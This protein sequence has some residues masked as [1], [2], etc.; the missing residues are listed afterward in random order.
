MTVDARAGP[1]ARTS[2][3]GAPAST[4]PITAACSNPPSRK[5]VNTASIA[6]FEGQIG[7]V[8][9]TAA[10]A[11][12]GSTSTSWMSSTTS[13]AQWMRVD[14]GSNYTISISPEPIFICCMFTSKTH[15]PSVARVTPA[16]VCSLGL[17]RKKMNPSI[18]TRRAL[19]AVINAE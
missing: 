13:G 12:D 9:Y 8:A 18:G 15:K 7:Q 1:Q 5:I 3:I 17:S 4:W 2:S 10:K 16:T 14:L 11:V 19:R 6:A